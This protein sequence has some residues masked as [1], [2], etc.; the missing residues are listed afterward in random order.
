LVG[1]D[2]ELPEM[3][4]PILTG[5]IKRRMLI[6]FRV[7]ATVMQKFLPAPFRPKLHRGYSIAGICLIRLEHIRPAGLPAFLGFSSENAAHRIAVE[8][9]DPSGE[10]K[11]GVFIPRRDTA[12]R[13]NHLTGG[14]IFSGE[15]HLATFHVVD[16]GTNVD[17][18]MES[19]DKAVSVQVRGFD[20]DVLPPASCFAS[21]AESSH[22]FECGA[23]GYSVTC[24]PHRLD[25]LC[26]KTLNWRVRALT[27]E[28]VESSF[29]S[30]T[31]HF[32]ACS[33][34]FDHALIMRDIPHEWHHAAD[35][36]TESIS[37]HSGAA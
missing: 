15:H 27:I 31:S 29:F 9:D 26:L 19:C 21:L 1:I 5:I 10:Q 18:T 3:K 33:V 25:G 16:D 11:E 23:L 17:F 7:E 36:V 22:F 28:Q 34:E 12:S 4:I 20:S 8:W 2:L 14:R 6:N 32:P 37:T 13:L 30:D 24:N 35:M